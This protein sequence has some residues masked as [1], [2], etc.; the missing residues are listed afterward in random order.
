M[1]TCCIRYIV[2]ANKMNE[3]EKYAHTW[4]ALVEK[5]GGI[6]HGYFLPCKDSCEFMELK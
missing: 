4:I 5:Y 6:Y 1:F 2:D 3:F